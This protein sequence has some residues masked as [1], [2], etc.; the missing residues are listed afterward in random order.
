MQNERKVIRVTNKRADRLKQSIEGDIHDGCLQN[1]ILVQRD[2]HLI[3]SKHTWFTWNLQYVAC[4]TVLGMSSHSK[5]CAKRNSA[6]TLSE[7]T[8]TKQER[9]A[10]WRWHGTSDPETQGGELICD[11]IFSDQWLLTTLKCREKGLVSTV[12]SA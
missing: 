4:P 10:Q 11:A 6:T 5:K 7:L 9:S 12:L 2:K 8:H 1:A 3:T